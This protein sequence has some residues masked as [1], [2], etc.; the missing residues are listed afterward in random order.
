VL[1]IPE[2][3]PWMIFSPSKAHLFSNSRLVSSRDD[4]P[5]PRV[6]SEIEEARRAAVRATHKA[7][8]EPRPDPYGSSELMTTVAGLNLKNKKRETQQDEELGKNVCKNI[9]MSTI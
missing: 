6:F 8:D 5:L 2:G 1:S 3:F 4:Q 7:A 9:E